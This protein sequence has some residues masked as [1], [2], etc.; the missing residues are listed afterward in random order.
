MGLKSRGTRLMTSLTLLAAF[1]SCGDDDGSGGTFPV[2]DAGASFDAAAESQASERTTDETVTSADVEMDASATSEDTDELDV[3]LDELGQDAGGSVVDADVS[4]SSSLAPDAAPSDTTLP[5]IDPTIAASTTEIS[6]SVPTSETS[7]DPTS[8]SETTTADVD[9]RWG[10]AGGLTPTLTVSGQLPASNVWSGVVYVEEDVVLPSNATLTIEP[11]TRVVVNADTSVDL[12]GVIGDPTVL[13]NGTP[14]APVVFC[15]ATEE[16]GYWAGL[17]VG[18]GVTTDSIIRSLRVFDAGG[19][20]PAVRVDAEVS[21][22]GLWVGGSADVGVQASAFGA[23]SSG[24]T[25]Q[26][27]AAAVVLTTPLAV[28]HFPLGGTFTD[29]DENLVRLTFSR[30]EES[31]TYHDVGIPYLQEVSAEVMAQAVVTFEAGVE[32]RFVADTEFEVGAFANVATF[33]VTGTE[34]AP[35]VFR[36]QQQEPGYWHGV[37]IGPNVSSA[38]SVV[39]LEVRDAGGGEYYALDVEAP[40]TMQHVSLRG[41]SEGARL[42]ETGLSPQSTDW[43]IQGGEHAPLTVHPNALTR[44][45]T[46][47]D[48]S[49]NGEDRIIITSGTNVSEG[50]VLPHGI[51]YFVEGDWDTRDGSELTFTSGTEF[52]MGADTNVTFGAFGSAPSVTF[53][54]TSDAPIVFRSEVAN[55]AGFWQGLLIG[56]NVQTGS[57]MTWTELSDAGGPESNA[58]ALRLQKAVF[59]VTNSSFTNFDN[60]GIFIDNEDNATIY[61]DPG[62][63]NTFTPGA[64]ALG[65]VGN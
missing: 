40:L 37:I 58:A 29:N 19:D 35:V 14:E 42:G 62:L 52:I 31:T 21:I 65:N 28:T 11:G 50:D 20:G 45:P 23:D 27:S 26:D 12:G 16:P 43:S 56:T 33:N 44:I 18:A 25:V 61:E 15:G 46:G 4:S 53:A 41:N 57:S 1:P 38:S 9:P 47:G 3:T 30:V 2:P 10:C 55:F 32:Y 13:V 48:Y 59:P 22:D 7:L 6:S 60:Y 36:G 39:H 51:P 63:N 17:H 64:G 54:G 8:S 34:Q 24:L 49:G 5:P